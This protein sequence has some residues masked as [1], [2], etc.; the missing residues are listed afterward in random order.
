MNNTTSPTIHI[1]QQN[2]NK[3]LI[4][5]LHLLNAA[6]PDDFNIILLQEPWFG[7]TKN[8]RS[9]HCW[10]VLYPN[11][12][13]ADTTKPLRSII[14]INTN[15]PTNLYVQI[16]FNSPDVTG[17][18]IT[19]DLQTV[20]IINVYNDC[21][22]ND[23]ID[24][25]SI[26]LSQKFPSEQVPCNT[27]IILAGNFNRYHSLWE[28]ERNA[29]LTSSEAALH[30][31]LEIVDTLTSAWHSHHAS[32]PCRPYPPEIGHAQTTSGAP[33]TP[34]TCSQNATPTR[35]CGVPTLITSLS[36]PL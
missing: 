30:P 7:P 23:A 22:N 28:D 13:Y 8:T 20:L 14:F 29:H 11:T 2:V 15:I 16:Q 21:K 6:S 26:F 32:R 19:F 10:R 36:S 33:T 18:Q 35:A 5:Q 17:V 31:L 1:W 27:H 9:S 24:E 25:V 4:S 34:P 12:H 3:S